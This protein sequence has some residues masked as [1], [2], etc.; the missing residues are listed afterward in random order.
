MDEISVELKTKQQAFNCY[1][2]FV[3]HGA[4]LINCDQL[5]TFGGRIRLMVS[6]VELKKSLACD[7]K[8]VWI[9]AKN[10]KG[11]NNFGVQLIGDNAVP[12]YQTLKNY[13]ADLL[14]DN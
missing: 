8:L 3:T 9:S 14:D 10:A 4:L 1:L 7:A 5:L 11:K 13:L 12:L 6:F 2:P